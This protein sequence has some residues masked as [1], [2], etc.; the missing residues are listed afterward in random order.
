M[1]GM[2]TNTKLLMKEWHTLVKAVPE[3]IKDAARGGR[4]LVDRVDDF[5]QLR[6]T[7]GRLGLELFDRRL[8]E[9]NGNGLDP[10]ASPRMQQR[11]VASSFET[12][13][14]PS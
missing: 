1:R 14:S 12:C 6:K 7:C 13:R 11:V 4:T 3:Y 2:W 8:T 5:D 9:F 10:R